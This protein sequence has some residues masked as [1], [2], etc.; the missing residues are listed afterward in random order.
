M[1][2]IPRKGADPYFGFAEGGQE[3]TGSGSVDA[4]VNFRSPDITSFH[5]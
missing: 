5:D 2:Q 4:K 1:C 3:L